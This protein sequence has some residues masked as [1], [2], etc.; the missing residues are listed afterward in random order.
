MKS[1]LIDEAIKNA[2]KPP[3]RRKGEGEMRK[4][5][6]YKLVFTPDG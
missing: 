3:N 4:V 2:G 1:D 6:G 5:T